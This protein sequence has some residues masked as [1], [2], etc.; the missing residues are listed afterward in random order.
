MTLTLP[1]DLGPR[2]SPLHFLAALG[3]GGISVTFFLWFLF[4]VPH[5]G[6]QVPVF[7]DISAALATGSPAMQ[8]MIWTGWA[9]IA[10]FSLLHLRLLLWNLREY[11]AFRRSPAHAAL[12]SS[13]GETQLLALPLTLAMTVN[14]GFILGL[15]FVPGLW[16]VVE[17]LFPLA[18]LAFLGI[19]AWALALLG[20]FFGRVLGEGGFDCGK[21]NS[22]AQMLPAF[23]LAMVGVGLAAPAS[24]SATPL[25]VGASIVASTFFVVAAVLLGTVQLIL[26]FRAMMENGA[27][28][29]GAPTLWIAIPIVTVLA[30]ALLRQG[31]GLHASFDIHADAAENFPLLT[32]LLAVQLAFGLL[33]LAVLTRVRYFARFVL[34]EERSPGAWALVCPAV[35]LSVMVQFWL[36]K[37][38][39]PAGLVAKF[40][41]GYW[42]VTAAAILLQMVSV[43]LAMRIAGNALA[44]QR[45]AA[46]IPAE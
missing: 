9:A 4:W 7:E 17:V 29:E 16:S 18:M 30:I 11:A 38:L 33:G 46:A 23:A 42:A 19:G 6:Q 13:N 8:A 10:L 22:L 28:V 3:A 45:P 24:M 36:N 44:P 21:N 39:V 15:V 25:T 14:A 40:S 12:L 41:T 34:G 27:S 5:P 2:Y 26:G 35:A 43:W 37:G 32:R 20:R 1:R 31:H